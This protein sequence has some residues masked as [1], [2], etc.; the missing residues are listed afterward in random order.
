M[1]EFE[2]FYRGE[3][4]RLLRLCFL[5]TLDAEVAADASQEAMARAWKHWD[6]ISETNPAAWVRTVA[7]NLCRSRWRRLAVEARLL[8]KTYTVERDLA[9]LPEIGLPELELH[10]ALKKLAPRQREAIAL[11]YW[12]DLSV[13]DCAEVMGTSVGTVKSNLSRGV[14]N[15]HV[16]SPWRKSYERSQAETRQPRPRGRAHHRAPRHRSRSAGAAPFGVAARGARRSVRAGR[17]RRSRGGRE[18]DRRRPRRR[19]ASV[20]CARRRWAVVPAERKHV[21]HDEEWRCLRDDDAF[22]DVAST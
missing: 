4:A 19:R 8:P 15:S 13:A 11:F 1:G 20:G 6:A 3:S 21:P 18:R 22:R 14:S 16:C 17:G 12:A 5:T 9:H 10:A 2:A 7:L